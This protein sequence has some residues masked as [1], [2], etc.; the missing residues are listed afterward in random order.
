MAHKTHRFSLSPLLP[1]YFEYRAGARPGQDIDTAFGLDVSF[2]KSDVS[3]SCPECKRDAMAEVRDALWATFYP[4]YAAKRSIADAGGRYPFGRAPITLWGRSMIR[5]EVRTPSSTDVASLGPYEQASADTIIEATTATIA[6]A[7]FRV[8][9][10]G[11]LPFY[12]DS[13]LACIDVMSKHDARMD[14]PASHQHIAETQAIV[15]PKLS[16]FLERADGLG[17][18]RPDLVAELHGLP[19]LERRLLDYAVSVGPR[20]ISFGPSG[21]IASLYRFEE[22]RDAVEGLGR[23]DWLRP[24]PSHGAPAAM[25]NIA[26]APGP[27]LNLVK[28]YDRPIL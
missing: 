4:A 19:V 2:S 3:C 20:H 7:G 1:R 22:V 10:I 26:I 27:R 8:S 16:S 13:T 15:A 17:I 6:N 21:Q 9:P 23:A 24:E 18:W 25:V 14:R 12:A 28:R 5:L 11:M